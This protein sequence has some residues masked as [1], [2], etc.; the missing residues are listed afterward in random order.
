MTTWISKWTS[1]GWINSIGD[2][3][4]NKDLL[5]YASYLDDQVAELGSVTYKH[6]PRKQ[7]TVADAA[8]NRVL[9]E[10]EPDSPEVVVSCGTLWIGD[11]DSSDEY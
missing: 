7:N 8:C 6:I 3:V 4:A 10:M 5:Q 9:D 2:E 1:N 11:H